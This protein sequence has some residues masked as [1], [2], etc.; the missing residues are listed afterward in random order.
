MKSHELI[1]QRSLAFGKAIAARLVEN[2]ALIDHARGNI[3][4]WLETCSAGVRPALLEWLAAL[5][6]GV[7]GALELLT[8]E[9]ERATRLRQSNPFAGVLP[10]HERNEILL[11][12]EAHDKT[13]A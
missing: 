7:P 2:P 9:N 12:F 13:T 4:R 3:A 8:G 10:Q 6:A 11:R 5:D 1:D